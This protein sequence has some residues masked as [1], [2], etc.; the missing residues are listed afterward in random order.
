MPGKGY[1]WP[2]PDLPCSPA[3]LSPWL[4]PELPAEDPPPDDEL[5]PPP[6]AEPPD[7]ATAIAALPAR[8]AAA[9]A[10]VLNCL[11]MS[12]SE[13]KPGCNLPP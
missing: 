12:L 10:T 6:A 13:R 5:L 7:C 1:F 3:A 9:K 2:P 11:V 4:A 8:S